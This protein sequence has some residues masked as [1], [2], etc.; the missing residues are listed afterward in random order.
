MSEKKDDGPQDYEK[1]DVLHRDLT[2]DTTPEILA[3]EIAHE[4]ENHKFSPWT[5]SMFHLYG[6]LFV[7]Y[8]C[9]CLNG[10]DG[11]FHLTAYGIMTDLLL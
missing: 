7:A 8:C 5:K 6:V 9:G 4:V 10:Y 11:V 1:T 3:N 2:V